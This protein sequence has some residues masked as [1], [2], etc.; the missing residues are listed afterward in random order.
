MILQTSWTWKQPRIK[1][2][3]HYLVWIFLLV[4]NQ[5][6]LLIWW[7]QRGRW[8]ALVC[9]PSVRAWPRTLEVQKE[10]TPNEANQDNK[11]SQ[12]CAN[13]PQLLVRLLCLYICWNERRKVFESRL[14]IASAVNS[15]CTVL[16]DEK[17]TVCQS[18]LHSMLH[19]RLHQSGQR[20][21]GTDQVQKELNVYSKIQSL[22]SEA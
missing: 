21:C 1:P 11:A 8:F 18:R 13:D 9:P 4:V 14:A 19:L 16:P 20:E 3:E 12:H 6:W 15:Y 17:C 22:E 7:Y 5:F 10:T 2:W